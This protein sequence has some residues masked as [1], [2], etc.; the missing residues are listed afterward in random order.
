M[1]KLSCSLFTGGPGEKAGRGVECD[2]DTTWD[3]TGICAFQGYINYAN[4]RNGKNGRN[5]DS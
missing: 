3:G 2:D 1:K 5:G 4:G